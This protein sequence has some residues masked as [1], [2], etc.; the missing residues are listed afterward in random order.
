MEASLDGV[1]CDIHHQSTLS[2]DNEIPLRWS[3]D[4]VVMEFCWWG[5]GDDIWSTI[6][7][8]REAPETRLTPI[9]LCTGYTQPMID[10]EP[11]LA[12]LLI[13]PLYNPVDWDL[14]RETVVSCL[15]N[16]PLDL[17][18]LDSMRIHA[19]VSLSMCRDPVL[20][21]RIKEVPRTDV[22]ISS[23]L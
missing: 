2:M 17:R 1:P 11:A 12:R 8:V 5:D 15:P 20:A 10:A 4:V 18:V 14:F 21:Q 7:R 13:T 9:V 16:R 23:T 19:R 6:R 3:P 22:V